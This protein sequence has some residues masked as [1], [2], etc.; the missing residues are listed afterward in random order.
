[1]VTKILA[2][3]FDQL[4][5][6]NFAHQEVL[7]SAEAIKARYV[8]LEKAMILGNAYKGKVKIFFKTHLGEEMSVYGTVWAMGDQYV[9]LKGDKQIPVQSITKVEI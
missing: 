4:S 7:E 6:V 1:M 8:D 9:S 5:S 2:L 3:T